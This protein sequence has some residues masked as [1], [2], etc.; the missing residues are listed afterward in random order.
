[1]EAKKPARKCHYSSPVDFKK[2]NSGLISSEKHS[3]EAG[4]ELIKQSTYRGQIIK[5]KYQRIQQPGI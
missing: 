5:S 4:C 1:M 3:G 2:A